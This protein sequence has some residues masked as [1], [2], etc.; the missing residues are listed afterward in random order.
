MCR[1]RPKLSHRLPSSAVARGNERGYPYLYQAAILHHDQ[2][3]RAGWLSPDEAPEYIAASMVLAQTP[4][5]VG[6]WIGRQDTSIIDTGGPYGSAGGGGENYTVGDVLTVVQAGASGGTFVVEAVGT[7]GAVLS[8]VLKSPGTGYVATTSAPTTGGTGTGA[9]ITILTTGESAIQAVQPVATSPRSGTDSLFWALRRRI[10][11]RLRCGQ[12]APQPY[13]LQVYTTSDADA[14][15]GLTTSIFGVL[16]AKHT[17]RLWASTPRRRA[18]YTR[19][20]S[21]PR[22]AAGCPH[23]QQHWAC[24]QLHESEVDGNHRRTARTLHADFAVDSDLCGERNVLID[25]GPFQRSAAVACW[26]GRLCGPN[27]RAKRHSERHSIC[28]AELLEV[29]E[30]CPAEQRRSV[31]HTRHRRDRLP[32]VCNDGI[33][34]GRASGLGRRSRSLQAW[35]SR[36]ISLFRRA[37]RCSAIPTPTSQ[38]VQ[39]LRAR[40]CRSTQRSF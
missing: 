11:K 14:A 29:A 33:S 15:Q 9:Q 7:G 28:C 37:T 32:E 16:Q 13:A 1:R 34:F 40:A 24:K 3:G 6:V 18:A 4:A 30:Q 35:H 5:P 20:T 38:P 31:R 36:R 39:R 21:L 27:H 22:S 26:L 25:Y 8:V 12:K 2:P 19:T 23:G 10:S 17:S